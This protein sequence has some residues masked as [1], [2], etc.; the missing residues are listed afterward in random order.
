[1]SLNTVPLLEALKKSI[2]NGPL[3]MT[4]VMLYSSPSQGNDILS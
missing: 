2:D 3:E 4:E 1:M